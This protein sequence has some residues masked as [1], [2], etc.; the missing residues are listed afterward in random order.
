[1]FSTCFLWAGPCRLDWSFETFVGGRIEY[2]T[3]AFIDDQEMHVLFNLMDTG[4]LK[5]V[6]LCHLCFNHCCGNS[7]LLW[8]K[9]CTVLTQLLSTTHPESVRKVLPS[10]S[11]YNISQ[12][13][14]VQFACVP[15]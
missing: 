8:G 6:H 7:K 15:S 5:T 2:L 1:M 9:N 11:S 12:L 4:H 10:K 3:S 14:C 13:F